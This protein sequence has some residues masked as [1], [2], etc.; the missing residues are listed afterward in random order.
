MTILLRV[1]S[2]ELRKQTDFS[3]YDSSNS[4]S[5]VRVPTQWKPSTKN[6]CTFCR[7]ISYTRVLPSDRCVMS[8][9]SL[10]IGYLSVTMTSPRMLSKQ[11]M[12]MDTPGHLFWARWYP[13]V[14]ERPSKS[15]LLKRW[16]LRHQTRFCQTLQLWPP[17][18]NLGR[19]QWCQMK[20]TWS[21]L[22]AS[23]LSS[24]PTPATGPQRR[25]PHQWDFWSSCILRKGLFTYLMTTAHVVVRSCHIVKSLWYDFHLEQII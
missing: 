15:D 9:P 2:N 13:W 10:G 7:K 4:P 24:W 14:E 18:P 17:H 21:S 19:L 23:F 6:N 16:L 8:S 3:K 5:L 12:W 25:H 1:D 22:N 20:Q 11:G